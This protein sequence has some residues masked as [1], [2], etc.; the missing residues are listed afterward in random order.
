MIHHQICCK[1]SYDDIAEVFLRAGEMTGLLSHTE[2][3][4]L[5]MM[6]SSLKEECLTREV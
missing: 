4:E 1:R 5:D 2:Y 6:V 3:E